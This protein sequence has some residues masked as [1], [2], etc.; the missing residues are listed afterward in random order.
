MRLILGSLMMLHC[1]LGAAVPGPPQE[2]A[3]QELWTLLSGSRE[4]VLPRRS[5]DALLN[6]ARSRVQCSAVPCE[7]CLSSA[8]VF[9]LV[10]KTASGEVNLTSVELL[11]FS[12]GL[13]FYFSDPADA[14][15]A[16]AKKQWVAEVHDF[17][18]KFFNG[19]PLAGPNREKVA[20][21]MLLI[22]KN[23]KSVKKEEVRGQRRGRSWR[24]KGPK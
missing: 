19:S 3:V 22:Q 6:I 11:T 24:G 15:E 8:N 10:G 23:V 1:L 7:K 2:P 21:Q 4:G 14:C 18:N 9:E 12:A 13:V 20:Q 17:Q 16:M 5:V